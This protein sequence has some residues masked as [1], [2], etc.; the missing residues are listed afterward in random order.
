VSDYNTDT[1][2]AKDQLTVAGSPFSAM[3]EFVH[4]RSM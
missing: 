3:P 4:L 1:F 2:R